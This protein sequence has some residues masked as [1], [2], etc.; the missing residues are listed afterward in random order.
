MKIRNEFLNHKFTK[1]SFGAMDFDLFW[2]EEIEEGR[3]QAITPYDYSVGM[4]RTI[5]ANINI[6]GILLTKHYNTQDLDFTRDDDIY[7]RT[8]IRDVY[9]EIYR[10]KKDSL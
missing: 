4:N 6:D 10:Q 3:F 7:F 9:E 1:T 2:V 8:V 5:L